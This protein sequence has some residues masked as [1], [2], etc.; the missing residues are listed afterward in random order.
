MR[1]YKASSASVVLQVQN[2]TSWSP[3]G[4]SVTA[5]HAAMQ[6]RPVRTEGARCSF[7]SE[8]F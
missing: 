8:W 6:C 2:S 4:G 1:S 5:F 3:V 7:S